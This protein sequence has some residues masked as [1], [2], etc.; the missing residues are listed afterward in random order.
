MH[1]NYFQV[2]KDESGYQLSRMVLGFSAGP[3]VIGHFLS[4]AELT[5]AL[6][7]EH[8]TVPQIQTMVLALNDSGIA[9]SK[10]PVP[11]A[12]G[13]VLLRVPV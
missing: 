1:C 9:H 2:V 4:S 10:V 13:P 3:T 5:S 8:H 7:N 6:L 12:A 11:Q